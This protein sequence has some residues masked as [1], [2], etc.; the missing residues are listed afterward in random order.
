MP[1]A[2]PVTVELPTAAEAP[3]VSVEVGGHALGIRTSTSYRLARTG[4]L[5]EGVPVIKVGQ[6]YRVPTAA[7]RRVLGL[8]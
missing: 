6:R 1:I 5:A 7:L 4:Q 2:K 3:T 8:D